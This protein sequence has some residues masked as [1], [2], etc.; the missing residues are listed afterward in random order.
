VAAVEAALETVTMT[1]SYPDGR[2]DFVDPNG[3]TSIAIEISG[4]VAPQGGSGKLHWSAGGGS[5]EVAMADVPGGM[6]GTFP[7]FDCGAAVSWYISV[8]SVEG[9]LVYSP[10][11]APSESWQSD[12]WSGIEVAF[13]DDFNTNQG[14]TVYAGAGTGNWTRV[15]PSGSGGARCDNPTDADGSGL[16]FVSGNGVDEDID[17]GST[18]LTSPSMDASGGGMLRY[19]RWYNNGTPCGGADPQNDIFVVE[20]SDDGGSTW[21][22]LEVVGPG[23]SEVN[24]GW[25]QMAWD[26]EAI[27]GVTPTD[28]FHVRFTASDLNDG[29]VVEAAVDAVMIDRYYCDEE[30]CVGDLTGD[31]LVDVDDILAGIAGFGTDYT[32]DDILLI[33]AN[34]GNPC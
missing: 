20:V 34:F 31:G 12:A 3:G 2:P 9:D 10:Y 11:G 1:I 14:W 5:G 6:V 32:V 7:A 21:V 27:P 22:E 29:S 16:C 33:L 25:F 30:P 23:G 28:S 4:N 13:E 15:T 8:E 18:I 24:G 17:D 26:V 19:S